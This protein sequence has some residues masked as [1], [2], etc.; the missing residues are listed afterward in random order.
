MSSHPLL[1][2][3]I[4]NVKTVENVLIQSV[5]KKHHGI[6]EENFQHKKE[7]KI[8]EERRDVLIPVLNI[9]VFSVTTVENT[10]LQ[11]VD[12]KHPESHIDDN[13]AGLKTEKLFDE[14]NELVGSLYGNTIEDDEEDKE[15][16]KFLAQE[17]LKAGL[18]PLKVYMK[19]LELEKV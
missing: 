14:E 6:L 16:E 2:T 15:I 1:N 7:L 17:D 18:A 4:V 12:E 13:V 5:D 8:E 10:V 11:S 9:S 3:D 19:S